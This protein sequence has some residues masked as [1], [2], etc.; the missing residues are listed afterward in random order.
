VRFFY[1]TTAEAADRIRKTGFADEDLEA[2][3]GVRGVLC[4]SADDGAFA[5]AGVVALE[6]SAGAAGPFALDAAY[7]QL[8]RWLLPID[9]ANGALRAARRPKPAGS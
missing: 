5:G 1:Q 7:V 9:V 2:V 4:W 8:R 3:N 6:L